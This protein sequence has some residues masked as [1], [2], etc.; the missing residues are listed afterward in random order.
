LPRITFTWNPQGLRR[1]SF[2]DF[3]WIPISGRKQLTA[4]L[5]SMVLVILGSLLGSLLPIHNL[6]LALYVLVGFLMADRVHP[7]PLVGSIVVTL[8][9]IGIAFALILFVPD[10]VEMSSAFLLPIAMNLFLSLFIGAILAS[11]FK[12][13]E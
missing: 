7:N 4:G 10:T 2:K 5:I 1:L 3:K 6:N 12:K 8:S 13:S 9:I 11:V